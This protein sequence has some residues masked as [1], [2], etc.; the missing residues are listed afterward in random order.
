MK[1]HGEGAA[2][3]RALN[4]AGYRVNIPTFE[5]PLD[6]L[7]HLIRREQM[8]IYDIPIAEICTSYL[9]YLEILH[10]PDVNL[11]GEFMVMASTLMFIKSEMLLPREKTDEADDPR[12]PLVAQLLEYER[13]QKASKEIDARGWLGRDVF[14]RPEAATKDSTPVE[15]LLSAPV[16]AVESFSLLVALKVALDRGQRPPMKI[17]VDTTSL[18][19]KVE[20]MTTSLGVQDVIELRTFWPERP[21]KQEIIIAFISMLELARLKFIEIIQP[22]ILGPIQIRRVRSLD[23]LNVSLLQQF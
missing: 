2:E 3:A 6:L 11:A 12:M 10:Q 18:K 7:L 14:A 15:A 21:K 1:V 5:G 8:N 17:E 16:D 13:Y 20:E 19:E 22:E 23:E 9:E 4:D